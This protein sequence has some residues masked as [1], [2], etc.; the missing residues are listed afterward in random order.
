MSAECL[1]ELGIARMRLALQEAGVALVSESTLA[2][3]VACH[4]LEEM[5]HGLWLGSLEVACGL[6]LRR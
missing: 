5:R 1:T 6:D 2:A 4:M 3:L